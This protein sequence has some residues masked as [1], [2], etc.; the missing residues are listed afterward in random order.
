LPKE[1]Y[2][3]PPAPVSPV[4]GV[5]VSYIRAIPTI[6]ASTD[7]LPV[8]DYFSSALQE[9]MLYSLWSGDDE[10]SPNYSAAQAHLRAFFELLQV[11]AAADGSANPK[12]KGV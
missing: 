2:V 7:T 10:Q 8:D 12:A 9:W 4:I 5:D 6:T 3:Y 1:F 11:K